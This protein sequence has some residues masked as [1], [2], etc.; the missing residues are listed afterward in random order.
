MHTRRAAQPQAELDRLRAPLAELAEPHRPGAWS[1]AGWCSSCGRPAPTREQALRELAAERH[2]A[3]ILFCG[4]DLGDRPAFDA[5]RELR[6]TGTP[7]LLVAS[8]SA[9]TPAEIMAE[10]DLV[11]SG[12]AGVAELLAGLAAAFAAAKHRTR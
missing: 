3:A 1:R 7:G 11:V 2:A 12:P 6:A 5:V 4:D 8:G 9:E 10:A